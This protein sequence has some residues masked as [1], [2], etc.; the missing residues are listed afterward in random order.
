MVVHEALTDEKWSHI[1]FSF[2]ISFC[3]LSFFRMS[4]SLRSNVLTAAD[5]SV[6][7]FIWRSTA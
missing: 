3:D 2:L 1:L 6:T 4:P 5:A 7:T